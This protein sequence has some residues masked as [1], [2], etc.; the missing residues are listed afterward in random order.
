MYVLDW[1]AFVGCAVGCGKNVLGTAHVEYPGQISV[2][3][4]L[5][6]YT[7]AHQ[8]LAVTDKELCNGAV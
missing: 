4:N 8:G 3:G 1:H 2:L 7:N 5:I 6:Q